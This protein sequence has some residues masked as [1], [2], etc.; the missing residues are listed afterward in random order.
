MPHEHRPSELSAFD[1]ALDIL[2][3]LL[4]A[5]DLHCRAAA[6][7][8]KIKRHGPEAGVGEALELRRPDTRRAADAVQKNY[9]QRPRSFARPVRGES[10]F[11][12]SGL[13]YCGDCCLRVGGRLGPP[14][15]YSAR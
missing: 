7:S 15:V 3:Q 14:R 8:G 2:R 1:G 4:E 9:R 12:I 13:F 5:Q 6:I 10:A 11:F